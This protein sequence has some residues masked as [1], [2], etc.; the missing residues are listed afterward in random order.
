MTIYCD[1]EY[2][3]YNEDGFCLCDKLHLD[4]NGVC[5]EI[6]TTVTEEDL[7]VAED[8]NK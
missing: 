4:G 2:C 6:C 8:L 5:T 7:K 3:D 1:A